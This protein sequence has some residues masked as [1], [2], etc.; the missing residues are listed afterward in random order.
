M[1][2]RSGVGYSFATDSFEAGE[3]AAQVALAACEGQKPVVA[4]V[5]G[6]VLYEQES[7]LKGVASVLPGVVF[8]GGS[9]QGISCCDEVHEVD[10]VVGVC[11]L[12]SDVIVAHAVIE[13]EVS[14]DP[15]AAG[16]RLAASLPAGAAGSTL[17]LW[18]DPLSGI[19]VDGLLSGLE[20]GGFPLVVGGGTGQP[21]GP[22]HK[23]YQ[24]FHEEVQSNA[25]VALY[26]EHC[27]IAFDLTNG[28]ESLGLDFEVTGADGVRLQ[29]L[30]DVPALDVWTEQLGAQAT[31]D[32][33]DVAT[34]V[35]GVQV[36]E[37]ETAAYE[38]LISR[39]VF[40]F[41]RENKA[42]LLQ[43]PI[44]AGTTIQLCHRTPEAVFDRALAM[45][46]RLAD[47]AKDRKSIL[48]LSFE[49]GARPQPF[50][51]SAK[52]KEEVERMQQTL[53]PVPWF[54]FYAWGEVAPVGGRSYF[55]NYTFPLCL[56]FE[57]VKA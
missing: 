45:A 28:T 11:I 5:Y 50:L 37:L 54:G 33:E 9:T 34:W 20:D 19:N 6:T 47:K 7:L 18:Y 25:A 55:H 17:L 39:A 22:M 29:A 23:T 35:L 44:S 21:W 26:L 56:L 42:L 13:R 27:D 12:A 46:G 4:F 24:Y 43:A 31:G 15:H 3:E 48:A 32:V 53:G 36:P 38:G 52:A 14:S 8:V 40:G 16:Q 10:R 41:D 1:A 2:S 57:S 30:N 51:G 49:C